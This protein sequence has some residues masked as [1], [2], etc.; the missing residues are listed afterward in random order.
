MAFKIFFFSSVNLCEV[1]AEIFSVDLQ[2]GNL[3]CYFSKEET[4]YD[5][6]ILS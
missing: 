6:A 1:R 2:V 4:A 5:E 3:Q